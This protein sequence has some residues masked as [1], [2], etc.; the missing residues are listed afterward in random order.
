MPARTAPAPLLIAALLV[1]A[2]GCTRVAGDEPVVATPSTT[3]TTASDTTA[4][5][6]TTSAQVSRSTTT[7]RR[8]TTTAATAVVAAPARPARVV[9]EQ[10]WTPF[11]VAGEVTLVHPSARVERVAFHESNHDGARELEPLPTAVA[12]VTLETRGRETGSRTAADVVVD[13]A[14]QI[15]APVTGRVKR[16]G[17]YVLYCDYSDD[18]V[19]IEPDDH[20]GWE[21]KIL[22]IDGV[23]VTA[24]DR[25]TAGHTVLA[26][27]PTQLPFESQVDEAR[28]ADPA[29]PH[30]HIEVVD[31]AIPDRPTP[32]GGC[33]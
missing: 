23:R 30:V 26:P 18:Y 7:R 2:S 29:W 31:P 21:V 22:H 33:K 25:V 28:R 6:T 14:V 15:R 32:G 16:A 9:T 13:P 1:L 3:A 11:A 24:G 4:V 27:R 19:V 5:T 17:T 10:P 20:P 8:P 12:P